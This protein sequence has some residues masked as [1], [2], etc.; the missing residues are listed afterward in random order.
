MHRAERV[1]AELA[2]AM[3]S[4]GDARTALE[5]APAA[6]VS[7]SAESAEAKAAA[8]PPQPPPPPPRLE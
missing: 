7:Q 6:G 2:G 4:Q 3:S 8:G 5:P 1:G